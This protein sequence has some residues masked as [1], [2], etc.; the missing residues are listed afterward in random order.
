MRDPTGA[1]FEDEDAH[2]PM[3]PSIRKAGL[4]RW[5]SPWVATLIG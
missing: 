2:Q 1:F 3:R 5:S 4:L